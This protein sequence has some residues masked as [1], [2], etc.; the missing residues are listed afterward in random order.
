MSAA[1]DAMALLVMPLWFAMILLPTRRI[2]ARLLSSPWVLVPIAAVYVALVLPELPSVLPLV[3]RP[4]LDTIARLLGTE[5]GATIAW[6]HFLAFDAFVGRWAWADARA[7]GMSPW[8]GSPILFF[9]LMLGPLGL[10][11]HLLLRPRARA[12]EAA[13][14]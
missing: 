10:T 7:R 6:A 5:R 8:L 14:L 12:G 13:A 2:T 3:M 9:V 11:L 4:R 1:F